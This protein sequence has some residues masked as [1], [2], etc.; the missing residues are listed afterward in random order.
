MDQRPTMPASPVPYSLREE[1]L[2]LA[3]AV[4]LRRREVVARLEAGEHVDVEVYGRGVDQVNERLVE[5]SLRWR[6]YRSLRPRI[7]APELR[8]TLPLTRA[9]VERGSTVVSI[10]DRHGVDAPGAALLAGEDPAVFRLSIVPIQ[11]KLVERDSVLLQGPWAGEEP[12]VLLVRDTACLQAA[13][14]YWNA[15]ETASYEPRAD[16][17]ALDGLTERQC[18]IVGLLGDD[19]T[20]ETIAAA[21][22]VSVRT[23]RYDI[24]RIFDVLGVRSRFAAG[25]RLRELQG[26]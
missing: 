9:F 11:L 6:E 10:F 15:V 23:V 25:Q 16:V 21:L 7:S 8:Y 19:A 14:R 5:D 22:G 12:T 17:P 2:D 26:S 4:Q 18:A 13:W 3:S 20:D 1:I 24:K